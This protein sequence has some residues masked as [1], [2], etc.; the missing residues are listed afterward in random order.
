MEK[1][2]NFILKAI[3][4]DNGLDQKSSEIPITVEVKES[5]N[6]PPVFRQGPGAEIEL[7]EGSLDFSNVI[8]TY[9]AGTRHHYSSS[10]CSV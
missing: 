3:A 9:T 4:R 5:N 2:Y 6:K 10:H 8:A 7:S 1:H